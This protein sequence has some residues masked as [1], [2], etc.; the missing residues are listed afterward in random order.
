[1]LVHDLEFFQSL[2]NNVGVRGG[3]S[4]SV[5][6]EAGKGKVEGKATGSG[7]ISRSNLSLNNKVFVKSSTSKVFNETTL[8]DPT[9]LSCNVLPTVSTVLPLIRTS[10]T[11]AVPVVTTS[12]D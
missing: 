10:P 2:D 8:S 9:V 1:M 5:Y 7:E 3:A 6:V 12:V 4:A 11:Y